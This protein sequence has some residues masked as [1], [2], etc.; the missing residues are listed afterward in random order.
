M[1][2]QG[3]PV[4]DWLTTPSRSHLSRVFDVGKEEGIEEV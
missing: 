4:I 2:E 1:R 3:V